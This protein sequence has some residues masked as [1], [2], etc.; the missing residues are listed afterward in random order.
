M[1][2]CLSACSA[3]NATS[4]EGDTPAE[5]QAELR[6]PQCGKHAEY[7]AEVRRTSFGIP[8]VVAANEKGLGYGLG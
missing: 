7:C 5:Q 8:H 2:G 1:F 6:A 3:S 4:G